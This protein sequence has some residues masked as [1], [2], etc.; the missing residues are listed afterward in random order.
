[1]QVA[2]V[3]FRNSL[4]VHDNPILSWACE[5]ENIDS[6]LPIYIFDEDIDERSTSSMGE[7][8]LR[9]QFDCVENLHQNLKNKLDVDLHIFSGDCL[10]VLQ[11]IKEQL[12][13]F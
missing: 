2:V 5:S 12:E 7:H 11:S 6:I 3:W 13:P 4:R 1:M 10:D 8:R 9:F